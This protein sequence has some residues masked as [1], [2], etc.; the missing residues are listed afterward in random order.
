MPL[1]TLTDHPS[2]SRLAKRCLLC[3]VCGGRRDH[4]L[5]ILLAHPRRYLHPPNTQCRR[6]QVQGR[7]EHNTPVKPLPSAASEFATN[8]DRTSPPEMIPTVK[9]VPDELTDAWDAIKDGPNLAN[10]NRRFDAIGVSSVP[11]F[12]Y[13]INFGLGNSAFMT[14]DN[15]T[16]FMPIVNATV[17]AT[18]QTDIGKAVKDGISKFLEGMPILMNVLDELKSLHSF[19][20][21]GSIL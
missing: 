16:P 17:T 18:M 8:P 2:E 4:Q 15:A 11:S 20:G 9:P 21:G 3:P 14:Q 10:A 13:S 12:R 1:M 5:L 19:I 6:P 7:C